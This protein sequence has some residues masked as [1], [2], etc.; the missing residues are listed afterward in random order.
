MLSG[1]NLND[2]EFGTFLNKATYIMN[3]WLLIAGCQVPWGG[4]DDA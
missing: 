1:G 4:G 2:E 3:D